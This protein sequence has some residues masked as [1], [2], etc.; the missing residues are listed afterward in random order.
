MKALKNPRRYVEILKRQRDEARAVARGSFADLIKANGR[1]WFTYNDNVVAKSVLLEPLLARQCR[2]ES[3]VALRATVTKIEPA[4]AKLG[5][6]VV[7]FTLGEVRI[8]EE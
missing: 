1:Y 3:K 8:T 5:E 2:V 7:T 6:Y 4:E